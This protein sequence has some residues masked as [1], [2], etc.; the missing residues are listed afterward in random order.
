MIDRIAGAATRAV[1]VAGLIA[2]P[3][4]ALPGVP[5]DMAQIVA[6]AALLAAILAFVEYVG[7]VASVIEFRAAPPFNRLRFAALFAVVGLLTLLVRHAGAG[8]PVAGPLEALGGGIGRLLDFPF[9]PVRLVLLILPASVDPAHA[10]LVRAAAGLSLAVAV[11]TAALFVVLIRVMNWPIRRR[12]FNVWVNLPMFDPTA[13]GDV[14]YRLKRDAHVNVALGFLLPFLI[15][16]VVKASAAISGTAPLTE[17]LAL[18][19]TM[20]AWAFLPTSLLMRGAALM[21]VSE[22]I[23]EKR[24]RAYAQSQHL[25]PV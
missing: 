12:A 24:R 18:V 13:G 3:A 8:I 11:A 21:R 5:N 22:L 2:L 15:P 6:L 10:A 7:P 20:S 25:Q 23:E 16:A 4:L 14:L 1:L 17:P 19:W 9:S